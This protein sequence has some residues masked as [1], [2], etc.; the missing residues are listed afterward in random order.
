MRIQHFIVLAILL[1]SA[2][3]AS[4]QDRKTIDLSGP[5]WKLWYDK[6]AAWQ[7]DELFPPGTPLSQIPSNAP[8]GGWNALANAT[9]LDVSIPATAVEYLG[10]GQAPDDT[11]LGVTWWY[12]TIHIPSDAPKGKVILHFASTRQRA[13]VY[14]DGKLVGYDI[15]GNS[16]FSADIS[17]VAAPGEDHQLAV[18]ITNPGG[19]YE[20]RDTRL[21][22]WG[23]YKFPISHGFGGITGGVTLTASDNIYIADEYVQNTPDVHSVN[24]ELTIQNATST[25]QTRDVQFVV[26][27]KSN[28]STLL[29]EV[30]R[31]EV[32]QPGYNI[33]MMKLSDPSAKTW[34]IDHPNLYFCNA[35]LLSGGTTTDSSSQVFGF[36]WF[37]PEGEGTDGMFR[38]NGKRIVLRSAIS[39]G[40]WPVNGIFPTPEL[41]RK[42]IETAKAFGL[43]MLNFHRAIGQPVILDLAD[44]EIPAHD[45]ARPQPSEPGDLFHD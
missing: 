4:A 45:H 19:N 2:T 31:G 40:F 41:A 42:Q 3:V 35:T 22:Q 33:V 5:G 21:M 6:A 23:R 32:L 28:G 27:D 36:R 7:N 34:D 39:W 9:A 38:L 1:G 14:L 12:R 10:N 37:S 43:N 8:T 16:P 25:R 13:E 15:V 24:V 26:V 11:F 17:N 18:R 20:W 44:S 29:S 30:S